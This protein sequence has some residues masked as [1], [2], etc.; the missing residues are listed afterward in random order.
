MVEAYRERRTT[1][2]ELAE[3][4]EMLGGEADAEMREYLESEIATK[5]TALDAL[6]ARLRELL[7]P[8]IPTT[9]RT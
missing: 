5:Q 3:A 7:V 4:S 6:D 1:E 9:A 2:P 8:A